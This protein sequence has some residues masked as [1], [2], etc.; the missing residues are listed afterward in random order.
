MG[1]GRELLQLPV[2]H[3]AGAGGIGLAVANL[4]LVWG[5]DH[6]DPVSTAIII[7]CMPAVSAV[8]GWFDGSE[9]LSVVLGIGIVLAIAGGV[10]ASL[11][12]QSGA[13]GEGSF[14]GI[15][16]IAGGVLIYVWYTRTIVSICP[17]V[18]ALAKAAICMV[19]ATLMSI[20]FAE[21]MVLA[22]VVPLR[23]ELSGM[24]LVKLVWMGAIA[25]GLSTA[26]WLRTGELIGVTIAGMHHNMVPF[27]V[28]LM[29]LALGGSVNLMTIAGA[30]LVVAGAVLSQ[31]PHLALGQRILPVTR[32]RPDLPQGAQD[33]W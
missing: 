9:R 33:R 21:V 1:K 13:A 20:I 8:Y 12:L 22:G 7:S 23:F 17:H 18:S 16:V 6:V 2:I 30:G 15:V 26:L 11:G 28:M 24:S 31:L 25:V 27:Y 10:L 29:A 19:M 5:Q 4:A 3:M 32:A 14:I